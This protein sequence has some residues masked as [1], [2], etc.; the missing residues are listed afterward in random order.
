MHSYGDARYPVVLSLN[1]RAYNL[2]T[3]EFP[4][5]E[6]YIIQLSAD[7]WLLQTEVSNFVGITR[8][9]LGLAA[10]I[11]IVE[12]KEL[13]EYVREYGERYILGVG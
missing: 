8:F 11:R 6:R 3:E 7:E 9:I 4:L 1:R 2:L 12:S 5:S 10:D 13:Q